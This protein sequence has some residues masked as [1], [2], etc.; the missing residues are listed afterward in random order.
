MLSHVN[1]FRCFSDCLEGDFDDCF[2]T[3]GESDHGPVGGLARI[4]VQHLD[5]GAPAD[6]IGYGI[7]DFRVAAFAEIRHTFNYP[8]HMTS[9][10]DI[11]S[12]FS[13]RALGDTFH[14]LGHIRVIYACLRTH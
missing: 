4:D 8:F 9:V 12:I 14:C 10:F 6:D 3:A 2:R 1:E 13:L 7:Y 5:S 11:L